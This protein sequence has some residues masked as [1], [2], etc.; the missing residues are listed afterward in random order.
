MCVGSGLWHRQ[1]GSPVGCWVVPA[2][3]MCGNSHKCRKLLHK[4]RLIELTSCNF[5]AGAARSLH[6][7]LGWWAGG[8]WIGAMENG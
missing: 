3:C 2:I 7:P 6:V 1:G 4:A 8:W 5:I